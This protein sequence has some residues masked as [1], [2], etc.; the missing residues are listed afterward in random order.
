[1]PSITAS[2]INSSSQGDEYKKKTALGSVFKA[3][4]TLNNSSLLH[5]ILLYHVENV[6][7]FI[8]RHHAYASLTIQNR[9]DIGISMI[10]VCS[11][12]VRF[13]AFREQ[14][15][16]LQYPCS[17]TE[18]KIC[19]SRNSGIESCGGRVTVGNQ[20][21]ATSITRHICVNTVWDDCL[22]CWMLDEQPTIQQRIVVLMQDYLTTLSKWYI[23]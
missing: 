7:P 4:G 2:P 20:T 17:Q 16:R 3:A 22:N 15:F 23:A 8:F 1:M 5:P 14:P 21:D 12:S 18:I 6:F 13:V 11:H 10:T 19:I 9:I